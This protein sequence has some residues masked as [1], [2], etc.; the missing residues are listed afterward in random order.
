MLDNRF[1]SFYV[2]AL[3]CSCACLFE[4]FCNCILKPFSF[5]NLYQTY[6][7]NVES[8]IIT[9]HRRITRYMHFCPITILL[10]LSSMIVCTRCIHQVHILLKCYRIRFFTTIPIFRCSAQLFNINKQTEKKRVRYNF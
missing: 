2:C 3:V 9:T 6:L 1:V 10:I 8:I 7:L 5:N 4:Y